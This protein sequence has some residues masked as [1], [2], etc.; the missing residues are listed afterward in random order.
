M[1]DYLLVLFLSSNKIFLFNLQDPLAED[2][3][4]VVAR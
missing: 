4:S 1:K 2:E 3:S